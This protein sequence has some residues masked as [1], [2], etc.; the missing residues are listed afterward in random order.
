MPWLAENIDYAIL[1]LLALSVIPLVI[2]WWRHRSD[3]EPQKK[4]AKASA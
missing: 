2:E 4:S 3:D 1:G